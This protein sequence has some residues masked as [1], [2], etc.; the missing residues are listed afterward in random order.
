MA[1]FCKNC[2]NPMADNAPFCNRC[3]APVSGAP[4]PV[5]YRPAG[6]SSNADMFKLGVLI[7]AA[8]V[9]VA[10]F[11]PYYSVY[12][13]SLSL[14]GEE[15][16]RTGLYFIT[17]AV[18]G[19]VG[20][21]IRDPMLALIGNVLPAVYMFFVMFVI[22]SALGMMGASSSDLP[23]GYGYWILLIATIAQAVLGVLY[24]MEEKKRR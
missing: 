11:L 5:G 22:S 8:V 6:T 9:I 1:R 23:H 2:G 19:A 17:V 21:L 4:G 18:I 16:G 12:G 10:T 15:S 14:M 7:A 3:G 20:V 24:Y 13:T